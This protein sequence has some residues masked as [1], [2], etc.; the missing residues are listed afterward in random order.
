M[1][2]QKYQSTH[3][4]LCRMLLK[5]RG[6][7]RAGHAYLFIG[8]DSELAADLARAWLQTFFCKQPLPDNDGCDRC[9]A[10][11][12]FH[13][14][15][16]PGLQTLQPKS[17]T[18]QILIDDVRAFEH[19]LQ[20]TPGSDNK[21]K[22]GLIIEADRLNENA[23]NAFLKTLEEPP[24]STIIVLATSSPQRLLP[25]IRSRCQ[26]V[27]LL[28]NR[29]DYP[30]AFESGL[31]PLLATMKRGAGAMAAVKAAGELRDIFTQ[32]N[33]QAAENAEE[34]DD[35]TDQQTAEVIDQDKS[36]RKR[37]REL[38]DAR[39][40]AEYRALRTQL[41]EAVHCWYMQL[42]LL[43]EGVS[44]EQLPHPEMLDAAGVG[45]DPHPNLKDNQD[46]AE[47]AEKLIRQLNGNMEEKLALQ[48]F[49]L[50]VCEKS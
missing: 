21:Y 22:A 7:K 30:V 4:E 19:Q 12:Q 11:R 44:K 31:F 50:E 5:L 18:R 15:S 37:L 35:Y 32:L 47:A 17:K 10:C 40:A 16:H 6:L 45:N 48:A 49:C 38:H 41:T 33:Q 23:Q 36:L 9:S 27:S 1:S 25:T 2:L 39:V 13:A 28:R 34:E 3:S 8:D 43:A 26:R 24:G 20:L 14:A 46:N 42:C 29:R